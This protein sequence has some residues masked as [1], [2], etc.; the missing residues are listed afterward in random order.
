M[1]SDANAN[2]GANKQHQNVVGTKLRRRASSAEQLAVI[3][4]ASS[5]TECHANAGI[6]SAAVATAT[7][8]VSDLSRPL[9]IQIPEI[10]DQQRLQQQ[11]HNDSRGHQQPLPPP[12]R[13]VRMMPMPSSFQAQKRAAAAAA[14]CVKLGTSGFGGSAS[15]EAAAPPFSCAE[16]C[17]CEAADSTAV[18][19]H[20][21]AIGNAATPPI[22]SSVAER[23]VL[24]QQGVGGV[25]VPKKKLPQHR[26]LRKYASETSFLLLITR[27]VRV[28]LTKTSSI[29]SGTS[30]GLGMQF[31]Q[32]LQQ[33]AG[34]AAAQPQRMPPHSARALR[35]VPH[36]HHQQSSREQLLLDD[37]TPSPPMIITA[38]MPLIIPQATHGTEFVRC[39]AVRPDAFST[40][41]EVVPRP[42]VQSPTARVGGG[43]CT[44]LTRL[45]T[46]TATAANTS[47]ASEVWTSA[48]APTT[49]GTIA[50]RQDSADEASAAS[51]GSVSTVA[52]GGG[53]GAT[54][55]TPQMQRRRC[56]HYVTAAPGQIIIQQ[57]QQMVAAQNHHQRKKMSENQQHTVVMQQVD[58]G[59]VGTAGTGQSGG[60]GSLSLAPVIASAACPRTTR[61]NTAY[62][63]VRTPAQPST[64]TR[65][66]ACN[67]PGVLQSGSAAPLGLAVGRAVARTAYTDQR[68]G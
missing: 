1:D 35:T 27:Q 4:E 53:G 37:D 15:A 63:L 26:R 29:G 36:W 39:A 46:T 57:Q 21:C 34:T 32:Q 11:Q 66:R 61:C 23:F 50:A 62:D 60:S 45:H 8:S 58:R 6:D 48:A 41:A 49:V 56:N 10:T 25:G 18:T 17:C 44:V 24:Q 13:C 7:P 38:G 47:F 12:S 16:C 51:M 9:R 67:A 20:C 33:H 52:S 59:S 3:G 30:S 42:L 28:L 65:S 19:G 43:A 54:Q 40:C 2:D 22:I 5:T 14:G 31:Q 55:H 64:R 68:R